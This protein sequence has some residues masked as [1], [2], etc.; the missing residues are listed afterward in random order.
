MSKQ[1]VNNYYTSNKYFGIKILKFDF[2]HIPVW[3]SCIFFLEL[4]PFQNHNF[5]PKG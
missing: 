5:Q 4:V 1:Q 3:K 2:F